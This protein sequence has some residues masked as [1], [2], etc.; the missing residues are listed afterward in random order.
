MDKAEKRRIY[1]TL[2]FPVLICLFIVLVFF[3]ERGMGWDFHTAGLFPRDLRTLPNVFTMPFIHS[4]LS[5]LLNNIISF[6]VLSSCLYYFY[7]QIANKILLLSVIFSGMI[8]WVIGRDSWHIGAS[9]V[10]F[11]ISFFLFFSGLLRKHIPLIAISFMVAFLYGNNV[12]HLF[13]WGKMDPVSWEGHLAGGIT[14]VLLAFVY[15]KQGPQKPVKEWDDEDDS[16]D[17]DDV[18]FEFQEDIPDQRDEILSEK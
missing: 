15:R 8:L 1:Y 2:F 10:I 4:D 3:F 16:D 13:P 18:D 12:W 9:G 11:S 7:S 17:S 14:G 5:H 6:F